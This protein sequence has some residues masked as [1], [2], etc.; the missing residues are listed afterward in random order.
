VIARIELHEDAEKEFR[1]ASAFYAPGFPYSV[2]Y[3]VLSDR[4]RIIAVAHD[5]RRPFFWRDRR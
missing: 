5:R 4:V 2:F 3:S 1:E